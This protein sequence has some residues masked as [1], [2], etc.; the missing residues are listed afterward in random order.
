MARATEQ[1]RTLLTLFCL[2]QVRCQEILQLTEDL[3]GRLRADELDGGAEAPAHP[4]D[5]LKRPDDGNG[6]VALVRAHVDDDL[7]GRGGAAPRLLIHDGPQVRVEELQ[8]VAPHPP[9]VPRDFLVDEFREQSAE[10]LPAVR[11]ALADVAG[12]DTN[13]RGNRLGTIACLPLLQA[14]GLGVEPRPHAP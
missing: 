14:D 8:V 7:A 1:R 5:A 10:L 6:V 11:P 2:D 9:I 3:R 13:Y 4:H 12:T